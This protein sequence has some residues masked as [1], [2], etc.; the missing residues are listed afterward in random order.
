MSP[1]I[2]TLDDF[3]AMLKGVKQQNN[4]QYMAL[5]P[6]HDDRKLSLSGNHCLIHV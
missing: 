1:N 3:L 6:A 4:G 5:C 2:K